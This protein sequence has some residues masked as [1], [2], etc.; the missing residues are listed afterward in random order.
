MTAE[1][2]H[3]FAAEILRIDTDP[4]GLICFDGGVEFLE[5]K[6]DYRSYL[7]RV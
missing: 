5:F 6:L 4:A 1:L 3:T 2:N 7:R